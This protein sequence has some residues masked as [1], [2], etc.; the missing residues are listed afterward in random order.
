VAVGTGLL[1]MA[2]DAVAVEGI[3]SAFDGL[4]ASA[5]VSGDAMLKAMQQGSNGTIAA[6]DLML[7]YNKS[8]QLV[9]TEFANNLPQAMGYLQK[10]AAA[11][12][13]DMG[14]LMDS[15][16]TG[17]GRLS[18]MILDNL[19]IQV[20]LNE[21]YD[22]YAAKIGKTTEELSEEEKQIALTDE[23]MLQLAQN[24]A[25]IPD[26][27]DSAAVKFEQLKTKIADL[28]AEMGVKFMPVL[29]ELVEK[30][31]GLADTVM[32]AVMPLI[33][34]MANSF[35]A[36]SEALTP[37]IDL[38]ADFAIGLLKAITAGD[39]SAMTYNVNKLVAGLQKFLPDILKFG[40][41]LIVNLVNGIIKMIPMLLPIALEIIMTIINTFVENLGMIMETGF[42]IIFALITGIV[43]ILPELIP[44]A[45]EAIITFDKSI[46]SQLPTIIDAGIELLLALVDGILNALPD[47]IAA[48]PEIIISIT[49]AITEKLPDILVAGVDILIALIDGIIE[50]IPQLVEAIPE[51][52]KAIVDNLKEAGPDFIDAGKQIVEGI[53]TGLADAWESLKS[54]FGGLVNDLVGLPKKLLGIQSP[55]KVFAEIGKNIP[56][57]LEL[58]IKA[59]MELPMNAINTMTMALVPDFGEVVNSFNPGVKSISESTISNVNNYYL[60]AKYKH[61]DEMTL[62]RQVRILNLMGA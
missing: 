62:S 46:Y 14:F 13:Q 3:K 39:F 27:T 43:E 18:P 23:V 34:T 9:G 2:K 36:I 54:W 42:Q 53:K 11:T 57:G 51:I 6:T 26:A 8:A 25:S 16:V 29:L 48:I 20:D 61:E 44:T 45:I 40:M 32:P 33:E 21:A 41:D 52:I 58:G 55:S 59:T 1:N 49:S 30:I 19:G 10:V 38:F 50:A 15:L 31:M 5:G 12:G 60:T 35:V 37:L 22:K 56:R 17:V 28:K 47:L 4:T 7:M 24:T